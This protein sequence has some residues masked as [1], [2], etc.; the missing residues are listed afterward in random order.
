MKN[1]KCPNCSSPDVYA[2]PESEFRASGNI[3]RLNDLDN[4]LEIEVTPFVC[5]RCGFVALF[6]LDEDKV[7]KLPE[8]KGWA[9][10]K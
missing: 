7:A 6:I 9:R 4:E 3:V 1:S 8:Q 10:V 5:V 2:N